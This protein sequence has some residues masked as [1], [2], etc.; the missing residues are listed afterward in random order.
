MDC[1]FELVLRNCGN[2]LAS[3]SLAER[4]KGYW[5][6]DQFKAEADLFSH[7]F[8]VA[9]LAKNFNLP[10]VSEEDVDTHDKAYSEYL[11][12]DPIDGTASFAH[13][14]KGWVTQAAWIKNGSVLAAGIYA[15]ELDEYYQAAKGKGAFRNRTRIMNSSD[16]LEINRIVDNYPEPRG[17]T[18]NLMEALSIPSYFEC[19]SISLKV[20]KV[21]AAEADLFVKTM[22]P[23]DWDLAPA[24]LVIS[25]SGGCLTDNF[26]DRIRY[27]SKGRSHQ[28]LIASR[29]PGI[30]ETI[31]TWLM[32]NRVIPV[33]E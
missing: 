25:E 31:S 29:N 32:A 21:A 14:F 13:G 24:D 20:C 30:N 18:K 1:P 4:K 7:S 16:Q 27:G 6:G 11:I 33:V 12:I 5:H 10:I 26:G 22:Q 17:I 2:Q 8:L 28:G 19:G 23:R 3:L 15:P 9:E